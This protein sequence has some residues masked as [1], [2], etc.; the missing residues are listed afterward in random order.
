MS[1]S[2][3]RELLYTQG[4]NSRN[5]TEHYLTSVLACSCVQRSRRIWVLD[6]CVPCEGASGLESVSRERVLEQNVGAL[7]SFGLYA[8]CKEM[9]NRLAMIEK[10]VYA[11]SSLYCEVTVTIFYE[12][13]SLSLN[14]PVLLWALIFLEPCLQSCRVFCLLLY[15]CL[16]SGVEHHYFFG[17]T[18]AHS[19]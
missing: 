11:L 6:I 19:W 3:L 14:F 10:M 18:T 17:G 4:G 13:A 9:I 8:L 15:D 2:N 12:L 5:E 16:C 7:A 1:F